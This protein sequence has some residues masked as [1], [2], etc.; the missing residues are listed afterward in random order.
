MKSLSLSSLVHRLDAFSVSGLD[1]GFD[2]HDLGFEE[3]GGGRLGFEF[4]F[5]MM[6]DILYSLLHGDDIGYE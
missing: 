2:L 5:L 1:L 4:S 3:E 6:E